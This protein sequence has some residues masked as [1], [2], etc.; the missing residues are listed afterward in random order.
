M[1]GLY[2]RPGIS[3]IEILKDLRSE[4]VYRCAIAEA[5]GKYHETS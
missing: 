2:E 3:K 1:A 4:T 5:I